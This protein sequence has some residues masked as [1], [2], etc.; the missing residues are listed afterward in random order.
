MRIAIAGGT[1][2]VG[3]H[4]TRTARERGHEVSLLTR[5][6]GVDVLRGTGIDTALAGADVVIDVLNAT[7]LSTA[8]AVA[9]FE[10]ATRHLLDAARRAGLA[11]H[12]ALSIVGIDAIDTSYYAG[13][14]AQERLISASSLP[15][16]IARTAQFH[17]FAEQIAAQTTLGP[18]TLAPRTLLRPVAAREVGEHLVRLAEGSPRGRARD[19]VGPRDESLADLVRRMYARDGVRRAVL[20]VRAP[21]AYGR[22]LASGSLRG[23][24]ERELARITFDE[25]LES[26]HVGR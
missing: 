22:G 25:W 8:K 16:T 13:K 11:H 14:L 6:D 9:F 21:G 23:G 20:D 26:D 19:L 5:R 1:G 15:H 17:E 24:V 2:T 12:V 3:R 10:T 4:V 18:V 7:T